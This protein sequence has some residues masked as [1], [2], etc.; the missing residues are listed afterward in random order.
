[1]YYIYRMN[2]TNRN[3]KNILEKIYNRP[4]TF[5]KPYYNSVIPLKIY[6]TWATKDLPPKMKERVE[7]LKSQN[8]KFEHHLFDD[9]DCRN[10]IR[11]YFRPDVLDAYDKLIPGAYK[12]DLWRCC[13][14]FINGGIYVDIKLACSNQFKLIELTEKEHFVKDRP[15]PLSIYNALMVCKA[16]NS[17]LYKCIREIVNN[18]NNKYYGFSPLDITGPVLLGNIILSNKINLNI[19]M[20]FY[21][22]GEYILYKNRFV[23][24]TI[25]NEYDSERIEMYK[26]KNLERYEKMW[27][28]KRIYK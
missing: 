2:K 28:E 8:P 18:V 27:D 6:Q 26:K 15:L 22:D 5:F 10:F 23:M 11:T 7:L 14:L 1:M 21:E 16:R 24:T 3:L 13:V 4:Y 9:N 25:Y 19:D 12:A 20:S 17:F